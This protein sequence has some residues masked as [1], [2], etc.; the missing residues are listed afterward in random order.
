[1]QAQGRCLHPGVTGSWSV[2]LS[3]AKIVSTPVRWPTRIEYAGS[4]TVSL[5]PSNQR[6]PPGE[7]L[8]RTRRPS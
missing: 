4:S 7:T 6:E 2:W 3:G 1:M 8:A 5:A